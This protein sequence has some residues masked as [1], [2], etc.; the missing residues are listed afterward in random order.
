MNWHKLQQIEH[1]PAV[2][3]EEPFREK[4]HFTVENISIYVFI[5]IFFNV[6]HMRYIIAQENRQS[7]SKAD[8]L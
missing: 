7:K 6:L 4:S 5:Y 3:D 1:T 8:G 2:S